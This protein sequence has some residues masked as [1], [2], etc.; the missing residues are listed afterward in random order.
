MTS[1]PLDLPA[2]AAP[3]L[4]GKQPH[5][6]TVL[7]PQWRS[8]LARIRTT[9]TPGRTLLFAVIGL[10]FWSAVFGISYR[11]LSYFRGVEEI[12]S[13]L[14]GKMLSMALL[15]FGGIL[16]LSNLVAALSTFFLA[17]DL[18]MLVAAP[19]DWLRF[20][21][22]KL[23]ETMVHSSWMVVLLAFPILTAYGIVYHGG[24]LFPF[25]A[26]AAMAPFLV[27]PSVIG[28]AAT[29]LLVNIFPARRT[30]DVL[31]LVAA[32]SAAGLVLLLRLMQPE[33]LARPEGFQSLVEFIAALQSPSAAFMPSEWSA[34]IIMNWLTRVGDPLPIALL[35]STAG[36]FLVFGAALHH[37]LY[38]AGYSKAQEGANS[39]LRGQK[40]EKVARRALSWLPVTR[41]EFLLKDV[42]VFFRDTTQWSQLI[43]L[44]V[45]LL[46]YVFNIRALPLFSGEKVP[47][48]LVTMVVFLNQGL[49]GFVLAAIAAR[50]IF[51]S[52]S[53]EGRQ[54]W[55]LRSSPLDSRTLL[56]SKYWIGA[57]PLLVLAVIIT[58]ITNTMLQASMFMM[59]VS[60]ATTVGFTVAASAMALAM[61]IYYPQF[62]TENA[63]QIPTSFGGLLFMMAS[64]TLLGVI[65]AAEAAPVAAYL[66][67]RQTGEPLG[68]SNELIVAFGVVFM[69]CAAA[70]VVSIR[71]ALAK[72][73]DL[74][75]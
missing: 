75:V 11:V 23:L 65:I 28:A 14:A 12:G 16:L 43:L 63:A 7:T 62:E 74:E 71:L 19:M 13:L 22:A 59:I 8:V 31:S 55:L 29:L 27:L 17:K 72:L 46:V 39:Y 18:D 73:R 40:W 24:P 51:P 30:R 66:R 38:A 5:V 44:A 15:A 49:A 36:A 67:A 25:V 2:G 42:R 47:F 56:W 53:L 69:L 54:L 20:Y 33:Q 48:S 21:L 35:W 57:L 41:R 61:G 26:F 3:A 45:L 9:K 4:T 50:F 68:M 64:V 6:W 60:M 37:R 52:V 70:T 58:F 32:G 34:Q 1:S 10:A